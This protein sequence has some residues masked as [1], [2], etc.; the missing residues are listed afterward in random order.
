MRTLYGGVQLGDEERRAID[1][2][3]DRNW[4]GLAE[5]GNKFEQ[6][7]AETQG[8]KHA[9]FV[10]S[11]SAALE[12]GIAAMKM[13]KG[14]EVIVPA[15]TFPTPIASLI[16]NDLLP[17]VVDVADDL[18]IDSRAIEDAIKPNTKAILI[19]NVAGNLGNYDE[20]QRISKEH[21][22]D[23]IVDDCDGFGGTWDG[24]MSG[25]FGKFSAIS[26]HAAHIIA[27]GQGGVVFTDDDELARSVR[28]MRDWGRTINFESGGEEGMPPNYERYT[29]TETGYNYQPLELQA[30]MGRVQ[31]G[32]LQEFKEKRRDN[33]WELYDR[34]NGHVELPKLHDKADQ[35]WHTFP[36]LVEDR[37]KLIAKLNEAE[38]DWRP[39]LS[40]NITRQPY[41]KGKLRISKKIVPGLKLGDKDKLTMADK[42]FK[43]GIWLP[44][45]P[46]HDETTMEKIAKVILK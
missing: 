3:L 26:T 40:G 18:Q 42:I 19:V 22:I 32:R 41:Y 2:V 45:H 27:T 35:C 13:P 12:L 39:I 1:K 6:E 36:L 7:L 11:G 31:L 28:E 44:V 30:A 23:L 38:I 37:D 10:S 29:Y 33:F 46:Q 17:V 24:K 15:T 9:I 5:E 16:R 20:Y 34:L 14:S 21:G 8:S 4:W 25:T 43:Q